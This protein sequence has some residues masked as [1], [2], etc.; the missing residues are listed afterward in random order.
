MSGRTLKDQTN[1]PNAGKTQSRHHK[2]TSTA[3]VSATTTTANVAVTSGSTNVPSRDGADLQLLL[4]RMAR[5]ENQASE[6]AAENARLR[7]QLSAGQ[8][9]PAS[10]E[11]ATSNNNDTSN[12]QC[13]A[14]QQEGAHNSSMG[15]P[16]T[17]AS[18]RNL[19]DDDTDLNECN[20]TN[21]MQPIPDRHLEEGPPMTPGTP[22]S[23]EV[24]ANAGHNLSRKE[25]ARSRS[26]ASGP[27][28]KVPKPKG[29]PGKDY[30]IAEKMGLARSRK[31]RDRYNALLRS[32]RD[33]TLNACLPFE[34]AWQDIPAASK[35]TLFA[36][37]HDMHPF[38]SRFENDW[39]T[40]VI[41]Q[42][43]MKNKCK[44]LYKAGSLEKPKGYDH[45]KEN[46]AKRDQS[47]S[48]KK[49][50]I[51]IY[52]TNKRAQKSAKEGQKRLRRLARMVIGDEED[53]DSREQ[54]QDEFIQGSS[55]D[56]S[57]DVETG[58]GA[59][60]NDDDEEMN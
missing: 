58:D 21:I 3:P 17:N 60:G 42:Q 13:H 15:H 47:K 6:T 45:L 40:E 11:N 27:E 49:T 43:F 2:Q 29:Q 30:S 50:V 19:F 5:L 25:P 38:L 36:V 55:K 18:A 20:N 12:K 22:S 9:A 8:S 48:C 51:V 53:G 57:S 39:A 52:E 28:T 7:Q 10:R 24:A 31:K 23:H 16:T 35:A 4:E 26:T 33:L 14:E 56:G 59:K 44:T 46:S 37:A 32:A 54:G 41:I 1:Q 34:R